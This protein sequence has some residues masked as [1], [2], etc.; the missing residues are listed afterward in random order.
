MDYLFKHSQHHL[1]PKCSTCGSPMCICTMRAMVTAMANVRQAVMMMVKPSL[2]HRHSLENGSL[3]VRRRGDESRLSGS[4]DDEGSC[5][6]LALFNTSSGSVE[7]KFI[8]VMIFILGHRATSY[9][10]TLL[11]TSVWFPLQHKLTR[12]LTHYIICF[13][14]TIHPSTLRQWSF[15]VKIFTLHKTFK[16]TKK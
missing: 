3:R 1:P 9:S 13:E 16:Q 14:H 12:W 6:S 10:F 11:E 7:D 15:P 5:C 2:R 8:T 4:V